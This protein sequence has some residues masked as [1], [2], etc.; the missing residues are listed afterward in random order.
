MTVANSSAHIELDC[1]HAD[2]PTT[3][4][5]DAQGEF[6]AAG[7]FVREHGGPIRVGELLDAHPATFAGSVTATSMVVTIHL[8]DSNDIVGTF[9]LLRGATGRVVKCL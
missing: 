5:A 6:N 4:R 8:T 9:S 7:T 3:L 2:A 1:A